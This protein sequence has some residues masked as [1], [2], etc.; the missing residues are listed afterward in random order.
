MTIENIL[1]KER[2]NILFSQIKGH[3]KITS[4]QHYSNGE[5]L[6]LALTS[7][8]DQ[9]LTSSIQHYIRDSSL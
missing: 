3:T 2:E 6:C 4:S 7:R 5:A 8:Q 9:C 1:L